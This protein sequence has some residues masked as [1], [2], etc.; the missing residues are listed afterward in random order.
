MKRCLVLLLLVTSSL[1][2]SACGAPRRPAN[3]E[4]TI[5]LTTP[6]DEAPRRSPD[7]SV[8]GASDLRREMAPSPQGSPR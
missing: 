8:A 1:V 5:R 7:A 6:E 3:D 2:V 4:I